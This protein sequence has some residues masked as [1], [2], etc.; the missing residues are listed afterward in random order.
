MNN[1]TAKMNSGNEIGQEVLLSGDYPRL[2]LDI[3]AQAGFATPGVLRE[4]SLPADLLELEMVP[5]EH[6][7]RIIEFARANVN[8]FSVTMAERCGVNTLGPLAP[9]VMSA[10]C[11]REALL[12][13]SIYIPILDRS[14]NIELQE[15]VNGVS[16]VVEHIVMSEANAMDFALASFHICASIIA[17]GLTSVEFEVRA[18]YY[19][20]GPLEHKP[21]WG[22][23]MCKKDDGPMRVELWIPAAIADKKWAHTTE[24]RMRKERDR[25]DDLLESIKLKPS[26]KVKL[27]KG[28]A[29]ADVRKGNPLLTPQESAE[30][31]GMTVDAI[32]ARLKKHKTSLKKIWTHYATRHAINLLQETGLD[33]N[34]VNRLT[35]QASSASN[36]TRFMKTQTGLTPT[37]IREQQS[38]YLG[39]G[40]RIK[41]QQA[42]R[43]L[44]HDNTF[45]Q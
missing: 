23:H 24:A 15:S 12:I 14:A 20:M 36:F 13:A 34:E 25:L 1:V 17:A 40:S 18:D 32:N 41:G 4:L 10:R 9:A 3:L 39:S 35:V 21:V 2:A 33:L 26:L 28:Y 19:N 30:Y 45:M 7:Y 6:H 37:E 44:F 29:S 27:E 16:V 11:A 22:S 42:F 43:D 5:I 8:R 38:L 31:F